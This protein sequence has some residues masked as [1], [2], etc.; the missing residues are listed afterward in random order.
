MNTPPPNPRHSVRRLIRGLLP[1]LLALAASG[2]IATMVPPPV[3]GEPTPMRPPLDAWARVLK[4]HVDEQGRMDFVG[5]SRNRTDLDRYV[6][7]VYDNSPNNRP[8]MFRTPE[9]VLAY[10]LNAYNA[11]ALYN[12][13]E[14]GI[15]EMNGGF[16]R[17]NFFKLRE[18]FVGGQLLSLYA[19]ENDV[20]RKLGEPRVHFALNCI[21]V[22]CPRLPREPFAA[23]KLEQQ[24]ER[25]ARRFLTEE[26][27]VRVDAEDR[28]VYLSE[29]L[30]F[31]REDFLAVAPSLLSYVNRYHTPPVPEDYEVEFTPYDWTINRQPRR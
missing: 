28:T 4:T 10:H 19:Y 16:A 9:Q 1:G 11:L 31:Y 18:M 27:N 3:T 5:L 24:L 15:P 26:R 14:T 12:V 29:I 17:R 22:G 13:L 20:I 6:S 23:E 8:D 7:W 30:D 21:S 2:C 25:E